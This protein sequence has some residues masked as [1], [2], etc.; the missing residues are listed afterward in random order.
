VHVHKDEIILIKRL[1]LLDWWLNHH[2]YILSRS[3]S[4]CINFFRETLRL[5]TE[6]IS[7]SRSHHEA[8]G[9]SIPTRHKYI[10][11]RVHENIGYV[12]TVQWDYQGLAISELRDLV[13]YVTMVNCTCMHIRIINSSSYASERQTCRQ[14]SAYISFFLNVMRAALHTFLQGDSL[15][16]SKKKKQL[17]FKFTTLGRQHH[18]CKYAPTR[19]SGCTFTLSAKTDN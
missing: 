7:A 13:E 16:M 18:A 14:K 8:V 10:F 1:L 5:K 12:F 19:G 11:V 3:C 17:V 6:L 15:L 9:W 2:F 4:L